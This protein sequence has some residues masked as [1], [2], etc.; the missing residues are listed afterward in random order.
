MNLL[1]I[2]AGAVLLLKYLH[3]QVGTAKE[4]NVDRAR[5]NFVSFSRTKV[6]Y[7]LV[8][9]VRNRS[10]LA[11]PIRSFSGQITMGQQT[12][13]QLNTVQEFIVE[14]NSVSQVVVRGE[15]DVLQL[16]VSLPG[17][18]QELQGD[19]VLHLNGTL[20]A[21]GIAFMVQKR[22]SVEDFIQ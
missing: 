7:D 8:L 18:V 4:I 6:I 22:L 12:I 21:A 20:N 5:I 1:F 11:V 10:S 9:D 17:I 14:A 19:P 2:G 15:I 16:G 13:S 3:D